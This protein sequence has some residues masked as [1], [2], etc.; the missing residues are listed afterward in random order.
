ME[1][2]C[3]ACEKERTTLVTRAHFISLSRVNAYPA[4]FVK[5][6]QLEQQVSKVD[7]FKYTGRKGE[8]GWSK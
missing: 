1:S 7:S 2:A 5:N 6:Q 4:E 3:A 8:S